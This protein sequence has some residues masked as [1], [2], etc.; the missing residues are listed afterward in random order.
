MYL[1]EAWADNW[2]RDVKVPV[3]VFSLNIQ[4]WCQKNVL[5]EL[6]LGGF[7]AHGNE[8]RNQETGTFRSKTVNSKQLTPWTSDTRTS[9]EIHVHISKRFN[10]KASIVWPLSDEIFD[11]NHFQNVQF[12]HNALHITCC[13][14]WR[15]AGPACTIKL[16]GREGND[17][18]QRTVVSSFHP[19]AA[20]HRLFSPRSC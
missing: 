16:Y 14:I 19:A 4:K 3:L 13:V 20:H 12:K 11:V 15:Q 2:K 6:L 7:I 10:Q 17:Q 18:I 5:C 9:S 1:S 8:K